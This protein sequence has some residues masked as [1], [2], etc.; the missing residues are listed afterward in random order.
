MKTW[1]EIDECEGVYPPR[2]DSLLLLENVEIR[3]GERVLDIGTGT[4]IIAIG[5]ALSGPRY[6]PRI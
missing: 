4:G 2:E 3:G 1:P 5:A 6:M